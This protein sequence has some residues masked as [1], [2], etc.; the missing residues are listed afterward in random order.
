VGIEAIK[1]LNG[2]NWKGRA[3]G[4]ELSQPKELY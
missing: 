3:L 1:K 4:V 2:T